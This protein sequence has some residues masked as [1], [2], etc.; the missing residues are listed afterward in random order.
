MVEE[1]GNCLRPLFVDFGPSFAKKSLSLFS[2]STSKIFDHLLSL[3]T[4]GIGGRWY[5]VRDNWTKWFNFVPWSLEVRKHSTLK[6][7]YLCYNDRLCQCFFF[8][9]CWDLSLVDWE[10]AGEG[11]KWGQM[12]PRPAWRMLGLS[13]SITLVLSTTQVKI[14]LRTAEEEGW[15]L[16][17]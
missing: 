13:T 8:Q 16:P 6:K 10:I 5:Y 12:K 17:T 3:F 2:T 7:H 14:T 4:A 1:F 15:H 11:L 9:S